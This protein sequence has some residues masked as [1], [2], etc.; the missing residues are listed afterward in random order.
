M[1]EQNAVLNKQLGDAS[2][3]IAGLEKKV[4]KLQLNVED[5]N[6]EV[7]REVKASRNAEKASSNYTIQLAEANRTIESERQ[8]R[9]QAQTTVRAMQATLDSRDK[10]LEELRAQMLRIL[11]A[12]DPE[13]SIPAQGDASHDKIMS[14]NFDMLRKIEELQQNL[15]IQTAAR[16]N[17][18]AQLADLRANRAES[19]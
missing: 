14:Q 8:L 11:K 1:E 2:L 9:T 19:P 5:L 13:V 6:H 10:E 7:A 17:A 3:T 12:V 18:D 4:E 15:R 16:T